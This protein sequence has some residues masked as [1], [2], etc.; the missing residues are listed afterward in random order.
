[1]NDFVVT[2]CDL[3]ADCLPLIYKNDYS[4]IILDNRFGSETCLE[5]CRAIRSLKQNIP[6]IYYSAEAREKEI[7]KAIKAGASLYLT[8]PDNFDA[9]I[10]STKHLIEENQKRT[11][12]SHPVI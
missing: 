4:A 2:T 5:V 8:K 11:A 1:M 10:E 6:I 9:L 12:T 7:E 3:L